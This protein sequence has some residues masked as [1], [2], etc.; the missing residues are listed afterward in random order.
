MIPPDRPDW[1]GPACDCLKEKFSEEAGEYLA[2]A[3][4]KLDRLERM[5]RLL[6]SATRTYLTT[7]IPENRP[8]TYAYPPI[9]LIAEHR[10]ET[11]EQVIARLSPPA[12][13]GTPDA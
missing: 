5:C 11:F 7:V 1:L 6:E 12:P 2:A 9:V 3:P 8:L 13:E 10:G 4:A